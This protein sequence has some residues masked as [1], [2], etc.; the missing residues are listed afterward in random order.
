LTLSSARRLPAL[1]HSGAHPSMQLATPAKEA[2][3][4]PIA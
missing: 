1:Q 4:M 3:Q 2:M